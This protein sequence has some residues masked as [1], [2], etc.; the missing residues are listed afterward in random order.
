MRR[1]IVALASTLLIYSPSDLA[2]NLLVNPFF[3]LLN[4][5]TQHE[6]LFHMYLS[7]MTAF[8]VLFPLALILDKAVRSAAQG[9][10]LAKKRLLH[11]S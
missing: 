11:Q 5:I 10:S 7:N 2:F 6:A 8:L 4:D 3:F 1:A 9:L